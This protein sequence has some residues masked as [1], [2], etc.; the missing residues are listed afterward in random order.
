MVNIDDDDVEFIA[1]TVWKSRC[2]ITQK[3]FGGHLMLTLTRWRADEA[4]TPYNLVL[5]M[6]DKAKIFAEEGKGAFPIEIVQRI[7]KRLEWAKKVCDSSWDSANRE[8][9]HIASSVNRYFPEF[10]N[11]YAQVA[12]LA[13]GFSM[14]YL[15][16]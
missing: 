12:V 8:D 7:E 5:M 2:V 9:H 11:F 15:L 1:Q 3:R 6:Q 4:P 16:S 13:I 14:G 10:A